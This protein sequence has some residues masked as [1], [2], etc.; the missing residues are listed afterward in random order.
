MDLSNIAPLMC[1]GITTYSPLIQNCKKGDKV[2][3]LGI[4]GL[5]HLGV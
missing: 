3:V 4:G 2:G 5:G 1:A